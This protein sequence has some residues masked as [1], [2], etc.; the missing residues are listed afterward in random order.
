MI[1]LITSFKSMVVIGV[2]IIVGIVLAFVI[3]HTEKRTIHD[4]HEDAES[5]YKHEDE[6]HVK[7]S[8]GGRLL[9][10]EDFQIEITIYERGIPPQFRVYVFDKGK[11]IN[12]D[13]VKLTIELHRLGGRVDVINFQKEGDY[14]CGDKVIE[15][16]HS[17][18][19]K[20][21]AEWKGKAYHWE[22][23]QIEGRVELTPEAVQNA[24]IVVETAGPVRMKT[25]LELPGEI[26][27]NADKVVHVV[28]RV[29]GVVTEVYKNLGDAVKHGEV[30]AVLDSREVAELKSAYM[31]SIKRVELARATFERK[32]RLWK[33]KISSEKDY[34]ASRQAL[35]E[36]EI[37][38]Q[39]SRQKL[40]ALG[41]IQT[42]LDTV[43][44]KTDRSLTRYEVR[45]LFDGVIIEKHIT[46]GES[47]KEDA[48]IFV[49]ADMST[50]WVDVTVYAKDLNVV[51]TGQ[52]VTVKS[53][54]LS[55]KAA[56]T[57][58]YLGPLVGEQ[59]RTAQGRVVVKNPEGRWRPGLF[60]TIE[61]VQEEVPVS[62]A[63]PVDAIQTFRDW[64]VVFVQHGNLFEVR[65]LKLGRNDG[66][67]VEVLHGLLPGER[68]VARNSFILKADL[69][70][71]GAT[72]EH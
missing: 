37:N 6:S 59:T 63:V 23:S 3:L 31:A 43:S 66:Q 39:A 38:L 60:V 52:T 49:L 25:V 19:V 65:P 56:G 13:E 61:I 34:L 45:A 48:D 29:S 71:A 14:L 11:A 17:F 47:I 15:E 40:L 55:L 44:D 62:V 46:V 35:A 57:L 68:Y 21:L 58:T 67:W 24:G 64:S 2:V 5:H 20:V 4:S 12:P 41:L 36:E 28:P 33:E 18:D 9:S 27:L 42:D 50:V 72:H 30:I 10:E 16:P 54:A 51:K 26:E 1:N 22:Y 32:E 70:K 8:R 7:G 69:G 53:E